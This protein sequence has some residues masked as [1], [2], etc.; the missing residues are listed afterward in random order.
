MLKG[1]AK[2]AKAPLCVAG[3]L[4]PKGYCCAIV[5]RERNDNESVKVKHVE[6]NNEMHFLVKSNYA[7]G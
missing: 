5:T 4:T 3:A 6:V 2:C 1:L 7:N